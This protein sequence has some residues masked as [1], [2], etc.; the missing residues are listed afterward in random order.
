MRSLI[1]SALA[2]MGLPLAGQAAEGTR[3]QV[4]GE[5]IDT[6][7]YYSG[8][9]G[10]P[11]AVVGSAHHTCAL[12]CSAGGIPVGLL[13]EDGTVYMVLKV[14]EDDQTAGGDTTLK[15]A[16]HTVE[17]D[18]MLY[19]RDGLNYLVVSDVVSDLDITNQNHDDYGNVP[20]FSI[21]DPNK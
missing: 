9:M 7:C 2:A 20:P 19:E 5:I 13:A 16:A 3:I 21:P 6:W 8:V 1:L 4:T 10:S 15:L 12:W 18:G 11:D 17:A 14:G